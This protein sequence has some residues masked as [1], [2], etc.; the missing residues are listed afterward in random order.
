MSIGEIITVSV[1]VPG[2]VLALIALVKMTG[3]GHKLKNGGTGI[4]AAIGR[5]ANRITNLCTKAPRR[6]AIIKRRLE[7]HWTIWRKKVRVN[8][9]VVLDQ[10]MDLQ[11]A[12]ATSEE[13]I[14]MAAIS[15]AQ[16]LS[17]DGVFTTDLHKR[18]FELIKS[19][20]NK[21]FHM[22]CARIAADIVTN[23]K[24]RTDELGTPYIVPWDSLLERF[25]RAALDEPS[26]EDGGFKAP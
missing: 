12:S 17:G 7:L 15:L 10:D 8:I 21:R 1:G 25:L 5:S 4:L 3:I 23:P 14:G 18:V 6:V 20:D 13:R 26:V 9:K 24:I 22:L 19:T 2:A 16:I 11:D